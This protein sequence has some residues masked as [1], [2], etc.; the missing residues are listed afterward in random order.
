MIETGARML[1]ITIVLFRIGGFL[2]GAAVDEVEQ[3]LRSSGAAAD[4]ESCRPVDLRELLG[5]SSS[6]Q[7]KGGEM[8]LIRAGAQRFLAAVDSV[9]G[10]VTLDQS[11]L[12]LLP[13]LVARQKIGE[14][15]W[16]IALVEAEM[17]F[18]VSFE[19]LASKGGKD[20]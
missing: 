7:T 11:A 3:G 4:A 2:M 15:V 9:E 1:Q 13:P 18:L 10:L 20:K 17:A 12:R 5:L 16:G 8:L 19:G 14:W 6:E